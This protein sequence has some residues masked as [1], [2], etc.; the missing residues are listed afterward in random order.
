VGW[1]DAAPDG[2]RSPSGG[3]VWLKSV[4]PMFAH[5]GPVLAFLGDLGAAVPDLLGRWTTPRGSGVLL[6]DVAGGDHYGAGPDVVSAIA[7]RLVDL[8]IGCAAGL[9]E[10][11]EAGVPDAGDDVLPAQAE[12]LLPRIAPELAPAERAA[13]ERLVAGLPERLA[14]VADRGLP[15]TLVHGD[16]HPG[17]AR[18]PGDAPVLLD[19][20]DSTAGQPARDLAHL[21]AHLPAAD[22][23]HVLSSAAALWRRAVPGSDAASAAR[24]AAPIDALAGAIAWQ[25]FLDRIEP[26]ERPYHEGDPAAGLR[27]A[28]RR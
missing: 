14:A 28:L 22:A 9:G 6:A 16:A 10:L 25:G 26:D 20:G 18:G 3:P 2:W 21:V 12:S 17:N 1:S 5:E 4:P 19:W 8:Q 23:A 27:A 24:L 7:E 11:T 13:A 15:V